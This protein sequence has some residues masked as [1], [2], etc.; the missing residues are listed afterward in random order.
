MECWLHSSGCFWK[1]AASRRREK[2][3]FGTEIW[4]QIQN[5]Q[6]LGDNW[7]EAHFQ[8][9]FIYFT[10]TH[11]DTQ[12]PEISFTDIPQAAVPAAPHGYNTNSQIQ[13]SG[14]S[15][16]WGWFPQFPTLVLLLGSFLGTGTLLGL[17]WAC[18]HSVCSCKGPH[19]THPNPLHGYQTRTMSGFRCPSCTDI[20]FLSGCFC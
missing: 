11:Q 13:K 2:I 9:D 10:Y 19:Q 8:A 16:P 1:N 4:I 7:I 3:L 20:A 12:S 6:V 14:V 15:L 17:T 5:F 18:Q